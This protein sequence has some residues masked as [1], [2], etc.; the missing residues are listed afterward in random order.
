MRYIPCIYSLHVNTLDAVKNWMRE[1]KKKQIQENPLTSAVSGERYF[2]LW[3]RFSIKYWRWTSKD[4]L[5]DIKAE[6]WLCW[7]LKWHS[8]AWRGMSSMVCRSSFVFRMVNEGIAGDWAPA[9]P[10]FSIKLNLFFFLSPQIFISFKNTEN[11][12]SMDFICESCNTLQIIIWFPAGP[13]HKQSEA[14]SHLDHW[15]WL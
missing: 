13:R 7:S 15:V 8:A 1:D 14:E 10:H 2:Y 9:P 4:S 3:P 6:W 5:D 11:Y 12:T